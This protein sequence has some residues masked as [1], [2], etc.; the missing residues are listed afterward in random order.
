[1]K[2]HFLFRKKNQ[3]E[4][5]DKSLR[6]KWDTKIIKLCSKLNEKENYYTTS[7]CAGRIVLLINSS[8]KRADLFV[9]VW[10]NKISFEKLKKALKKID[11]KELIYFKQDPCI[12][13]VSCQSLEDAQEIHDLAKEAGWKRCGI[14]SSKKRFVVELNGTEKLEFPIF[15][16]GNLVED[17]FLKIV[18][19]ESNRKL[20]KSWECIKKL[21]KL[22]DQTFFPD[23]I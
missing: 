3:L 12:L 4:K 11:S 8:E 17:E 2:N 19:E 23:K 20:E 18:V 7:S 5:N 22:I 15:K 10:H 1:M 13:H 16:N 9:K 6:Q 21:E 14:I